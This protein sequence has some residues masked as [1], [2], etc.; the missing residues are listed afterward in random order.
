M[1]TCRACTSTRMLMFLPLGA[2]PPAN[3]FL[4][5]DQLS[6]PEPSFSLDTH[7]CLAC[8]LIQVANVIPPD[9]FRNY[10]YVPSASDT[11]HGHF[12]A[13]AASLGG[14]LGLSSRD[15]VVDIGSNDG[16][17]LTEW[18]RR[19]GKGLGIEP[20][21]NLTE[22]ARKRGVNVVNEY[23]SPALAASVRADHG[24]ASVIVTTNTFNHIDDLLD[25]MRGVVVLLAEGGTFIV[26]VPRRP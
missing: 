19:G 18:A 15:L 9:F 14:R 11:M 6:D 21:R 12:G 1:T 20:A 16:L 13:L 24:P 3:A 5:A 10:V 26:E 4:R 25:F 23:F 7:V 8:G 17:F 2:H 22:I